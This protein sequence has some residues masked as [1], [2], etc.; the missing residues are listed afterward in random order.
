MG[1]NKQELR[2]VIRKE[3]LAMAPQDHQRRS[4]ALCRLVLQ[5]PVYRQA[6]TLYGYIPFNR[7]V[8]ILPLLEQA[9][10][11]GKQVAL[12]KCRGSEMTFILTDDLSKLRLTGR[13]VP[14]PES[15]G[16]VATDP[17]GLVIVPGLVFDP[18]G[19]RIGYGGGYYDRFLAAHPLHTT[20]ALCFD[21]QMVPC[22]PAEPHDIPV[23]TVFWI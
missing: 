21:F 6:K 18:N 10:A 1:L 2:A 23:D 7:E 19:H 12:P 13:G 9:L 3:K 14:E 17:Q 20:I 16:P 15:D 11:D 22:I 8:Q 5:S 4:E